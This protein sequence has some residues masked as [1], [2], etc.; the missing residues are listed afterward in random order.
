MQRGPLS[1]VVA[2]VAFFSIWSVAGL[3]GFHTYLTAL[4]MTTNE[5]V[6][7]HLSS[8][9][10]DS[11]IVYIHFDMTDLEYILQIKGTF[12][13]STG[14]PFSAGSYFSNCG[15]VVC[16]PNPPSLIDRRGWVSEHDIPPA[17][18]ASASGWLL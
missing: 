11:S 1:P 12:K 18:A 4:N 10:S 5:D 2:L 3:A 8:H 14:N 17:P 13:P 7:H 6:R 15:V 16:G 9:R